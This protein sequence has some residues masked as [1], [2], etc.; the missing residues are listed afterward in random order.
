MLL[1]RTPDRAGAMAE[2]LADAG[3]EVLLLPLIDFERAPDGDALSAAV[4]SAL[5]GAFDWIVISSGTTVLALAQVLAGRGS[6]LPELFAARAKIAAVGRST[7]AVLEAAG[8]TVALVPAGPG[9]AEGLLASWQASGAEVFLP[10]ADIAADTLA[11]GLRKL[12]NQVLAVTA[13]RTVD[14]PARDSERLRPPP[15][16]PEPRSR[17]PPGPGLRRLSLDEARGEVAARRVDA[18]VAA[19]ASAAR[20]I[21]ADLAPLEHCRFIAIGPATAAEA[22]RR[23]LPV[24]ATAAEPSP[25][26]IA[27]ATIEAFAATKEN[28]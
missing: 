20:R 15:D 21:A 19:S 6:S 18:V 24:D 5:A 4:D 12:G 22:R 26:G 23:G 14:Y 10:Q 1:S 2:A 11:A 7:R 27:A 16:G 8:A 9:S 25:A 13:Y 28:Q 17:R 3:A